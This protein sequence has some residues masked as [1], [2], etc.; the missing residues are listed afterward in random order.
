MSHDRSP[1]IC[2]ESYLHG[3]LGRL[4]QKILRKFRSVGAL[5]EMTA[6]SLPQSR[7]C[8]P[9]MFLWAVFHCLIEAV[10]VMGYRPTDEGRGAHEI[11]R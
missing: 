9:D 2:M 5:F 3:D 6:P 1:R 10:I 7:I 8:R 11:V 4:Y